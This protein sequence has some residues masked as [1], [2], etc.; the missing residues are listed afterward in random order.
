MPVATRRELLEAGVHFGHQTRRWNPKMSRFLYGERSGIYIIDL[1]K[2]LSGLQEA[3]DFVRELGRREGVVLFVGTKKQAQDVVAD[4]AGRVGMPYVN[5]R[6]LGGMLTNFQTISG[7]LARLRELR[8]MERSGAFEY[9]P[10]KEVIRLRNEKEK[11]ERNLGGIQDLERL[12]DAIFVID[13]KKEHI[14]V[15]EAR[16]LGLPIIAIVDTNCDPDEVDYIIPGN[17]DAIR[18]VSLVARV[19]ADALE[20][21]RGQSWEEFAM[22]SAG[23]EAG[24][25]GGYVTQT[26][27]PGPPETPVGA[28][29]TQVFEPEPAGSASAAGTPVSTPAADEIVPAESP[30][31]PVPPEETAAEAAETAETAETEVAERSAAPSAPSAEEDAGPPEPATTPG[32]EDPSPGP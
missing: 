7:R 19:I 17:D 24:G 18:A 3:Y 10:K 30:E 13:T 5:T 2:T 31:P 4:Q 8:E 25:N 12:P 15:T 11:L 22:R 1:E 27:E 23:S 29:S 9:L 20:E 21:G 16:K 26:F 32:A 14:A 28:S 6:W